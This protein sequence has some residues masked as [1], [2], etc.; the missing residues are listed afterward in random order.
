LEVDQ[1]KARR[2]AAR[3][4]RFGLKAN[5]AMKTALAGGVKEHR[6]LPSRRSVYTVVGRQGD[7]FID[8][9]RSYC[10]CSDYFFRVLRGKGQTCYH[11]LSYK[12]ASELGLVDVV[13]FSDVEYGEV[14]ATI[15]GDVFMVIDRSSGRP[16]VALE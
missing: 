3:Y 16:S 9:E 10:S 14:F 15:V 5:Q 7:E 2:V 6:F 12:M 8:P 11:L 4:S 1:E 13:T